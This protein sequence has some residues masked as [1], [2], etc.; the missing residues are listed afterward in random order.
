MGSPPRKGP[1]TIEKTSSSRQR[2]D[3]DADLSPPRKKNE[4]EEERMTSGLRSGLVRGSELK[5][6]AAQI[7][8]ERRAAVEAA[9][10]EETGKNATTVYRD[11]AT[12][13]RI[14]RE[15]FVEQ[16]KKK[17]KKKLSDYPEQELEWGGGVKQSA[18]DE[19]M[20]EEASRLAAQPFARYEPDAKYSEELQDRQSW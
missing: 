13:K 12:G 4:E 11:K 15:E 7:R 20:K 14:S 16:S 10:D 6:E 8:A 17:K 2:H 19:E 1:K 18:N 3:S 9:P 5:A